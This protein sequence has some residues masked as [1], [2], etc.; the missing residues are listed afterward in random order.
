MKNIALLAP[1]PLALLFA[2]ASSFGQP[3]AAPSRYLSVISVKVAPDK[4]AA[5]LDFYKS[6][7][8]VKS[9]RARIKADPNLLRWT[10]L[11][12][13]YPGDPAPAANFLIA[14]VT[15]GAPPDPDDAKRDELYRTATGMVYADYMQKFRTMGDNVG[16]TISH[17]HNTTDGYSLSPGDYLVLNR[18]KTTEG[19][20]TE[21][22]DL[23]RDF[24]L[25]LA[26]ERAKA[27][28]DF[29]G[30]SFS[31]LTFPG[32]RSLPYDASEA[33]VFKT[34]AGA[35]GGPGTGGGTAMVAAFAKHFPNKS[36]TGFIDAGRESS[37]V[38]RHE[39]Y[40]VVMAVQ[41]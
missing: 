20:N 25:P 41:Q 9:A 6:G 14:S 22:S 30:W 13:V 23:M 16:S 17:V 38:V 35:L 15:N 8:G 10:V 18:L 19:K 37:R 40:R 33:S 3:P 1:L 31:H 26:N 36:Y 24:R 11:Q 2:A 39:L 34:L 21:L 12:A 5:F 4:V 28:G 29:K 32:G 7:P 27:S